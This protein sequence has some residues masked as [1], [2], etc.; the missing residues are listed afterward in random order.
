MPSMK[1]FSPMIVGS[2]PAEKLSKLVTATKTVPPGAGTEKGA[3]VLFCVRTSSSE[4]ND[5]P[6]M[7]AKLEKAAG[8]VLG[9]GSHIANDFAAIAIPASTGSVVPILPL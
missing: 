6:L 9:G 2:R 8:G 4:L 3:A 5:G 7:V 1:S